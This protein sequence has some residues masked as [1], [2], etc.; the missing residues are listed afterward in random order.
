M[1]IGYARVS[2]IGQDTATQVRALTLAGCERIIEEKRSGARGSKRPA[3]AELLRAV[4][5]GDVVVV[6]KL[7]R[8]ARS[9]VD[10]WRHLERL[11]RKGAALR[12]LTE[13]FDTATSLG[14]L[15]VGLLGVIAEFEL[16][17]IRE[18]CAAGI[19]AAKLRGVRFGRPRTFDHG[20][21][22]LLRGAG[23]TWREVGDRLGVPGETVR[24][25]LKRAR[26]STRPDWVQT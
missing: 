4:K 16:A 3:L 26:V 2:S 19:Q 14:R 17:T 23:L 9:V 7:D 10:L 25:G 18:R 12:S 1:L 20:E 5:P 21:A 22:W 15:M 24:S 6:Y 8:L 13:S 11:E